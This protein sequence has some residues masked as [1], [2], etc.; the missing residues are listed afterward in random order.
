MIH[1]LQARRQPVLFLSC[2]LC[3]RCNLWIICLLRPPVAHAPGS[4]DAPLPPAP[5]RPAFAPLHLDARAGAVRI[6]Q[7]TTS[8]ARTSELIARP[9]RAGPPTSWEP[10]HV[11][12]LARPRRPRRRPA[13]RPHPRRTP[14]PRRP[15][16]QGA[17]EEGQEAAREEDAGAAEGHPREEARA[18][19]E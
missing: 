7:G 9:T 19:D 16:A 3:P 1:R 5:T 12:P 6:T 8:A 2:N 4:P 15:A 17:G 11:P 13:R 14:R 10:P 18:R